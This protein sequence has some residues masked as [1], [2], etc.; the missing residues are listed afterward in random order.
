MGGG[1]GEH[2]QLVLLSHAVDK[3]TRAET[4]VERLGEL[5]S[6]TVQGTTEPGTNGQ[7]TGNKSTDQVLASTGGDDSVHGTRDGGA[8]V[9][10]E[11]ENHLQ[12]LAGVAGDTTTEP[13][14]RH[15]T[16]NANVIL[17]DIGDG[18]TG[19][20]QLLATVVGNGGDEGSRLPDE[21]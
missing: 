19:V 21:P 11:H 16:A 12:E 2:T 14:E 18:H 6:G 7:E 13:Q 3:V 15:D 10:C 8:V 4:L 1:K 20:Q 9:S 5:F 17:E